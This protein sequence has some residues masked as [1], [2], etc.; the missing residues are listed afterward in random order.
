MADH[1]TSSLATR[2]EQWLAIDSTTGKEKEF[3]LA[4]EADFQS[5]GWVVERQPVKPER[6]NIL[7]R[8]PEKPIRVLFT[9]HVDTVPPFLPVRR[10]G[11]RI[12]GRGACDT[13]G[14]LLAM[15]EAG[16]RLVSAGQEEIGFLFVVGEEVDHC[17]AKAAGSSLDIRP[18]QIIL[19]E[20]TEN[21]IVRAQKGMLKFS[22]RTSGTAGHSAF[23]DRGISA[24]NPLLDALARLRGAD[25]PA[26]PILGPTTFNIGVIEGGVAANVFAPAARA[27]V[28]YRVVSPVEE[29]LEQV[30]ALIGDQVSLENPV[31]NDPVFFE[32]PEGFATCTVPFNTDA[33]YLS[34]LG[35]I[36]LVG[37]G[38]IQ[39]AH[40]DQEHIDLKDLKAGIELYEE[41]ARLILK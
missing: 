36:W 10:E 19:C 28:I 13:K 4:L 39:V 7:I 25:Y 1:S 24:I 9:T 18:E 23:P 14:G 22:L 15:V 8:R 30:Q 34:P 38:D 20:P 16:E 29:L 33:T 11:D 5:R 21:K 37:P 12:F 40:S 6:F 17:G 2:L 32:P 27:E 41:L 26:D 31:F 3:L 35:K